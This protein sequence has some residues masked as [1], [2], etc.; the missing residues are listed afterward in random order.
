MKNALATRNVTA[1]AF[2]R[3]KL[4]SGSAIATNAPASSTVKIGRTIIS[5]PRTHRPRYI[6]P[7]PGKSN[8][9]IAA[10]PGE[11]F[12]DGAESKRARGNA[13]DDAPRFD[14]EP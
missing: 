10:N 1:A 12:T 4:V 3:T 14:T 11:P 8:E 9:R 2:R 7:S 6:C 5:A 13:A